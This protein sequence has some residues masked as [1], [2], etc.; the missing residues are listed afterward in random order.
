MIKLKIV[1]DGTTEGTR[2]VDQATGEAVGGV[3]MLNWAATSDE[4][5]SEAM[6]VL[7]GVPCEIITSA[8]RHE[9]GMTM[10]LEDDELEF[11]PGPSG[12]GL[13]IGELLK[14]LRNEND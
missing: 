7:Q 14:R 9:V 11:V 13:E 12:R 6:M 2:V 8:Y 1:S 3:L 10:E 4:N 5:L